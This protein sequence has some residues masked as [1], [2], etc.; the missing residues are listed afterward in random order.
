MD[1]LL[2]GL[3]LELLLPHISSTDAPRAR[4]LRAPP[5]DPTPPYLERRLQ[6]F[7]MAAIWP[8]G[9]LTGTVSLSMASTHRP[10]SQDFTSVTR[11]RA[12]PHH[13]TSGILSHLSR[14]RLSKLPIPH[15]KLVC[16][17]LRSSMI[18]SKVEFLSWNSRKAARGIL[19]WPIE[20]AKTSFD[21]RWKSHSGAKGI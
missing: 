10:P 3:M 14:T 7:T 9:F 8:Q 11:H 15:S 5:T 12:L 6:E 20:M 1:C 19:T 18:F 4:P 16:R 2:H 21:K 17:N 13:I